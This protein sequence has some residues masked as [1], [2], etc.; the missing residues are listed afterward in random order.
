[1]KPIIYID[2]LVFENYCMNYLLLYILNRICKCKAKWWRISAAAL[3]GALYVLIIFFPDLSFLYTFI[4]KFF[5]S[6]ILIIVAFFPHSFKKLIKLVLLFYIE[7]FILGGSIIGIFYIY[8]YDFKY[9]N[10]TISSSHFSP[11]YI[12]LG[13]ICA[14]LF[15]KIGFDYLED[16]YY[17]KNNIV[18]MK[19]YSDNKICNLLAFIDT[20]N[21]LKDPISNSPVIVVY[22]KSILEMLPDNLKKLVNEGASY[23]GLMAGICCSNLKSRLRIIPYATV[24]VENGMLIGIKIDKVVL[25]LS[26]NHITVNDCIIALYSNPISRDNNF[27]ALANPEILKE[28]A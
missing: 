13:C 21:S 26:S 14:I 1:M 22:I 7:T 19:L 5:V 24:G 9:I 16:Y 15:V 6:V 11:E 10:G 25:K 18:E 8:N 20:G 27:Q 28:G 17:K 12:I 23:D 4:T 2:T 3:I